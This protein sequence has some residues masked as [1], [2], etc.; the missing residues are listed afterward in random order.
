M[1]LHQTLVVML[2]LVVSAFL[3]PIAAESASAGEQEQFSAQVRVGGDTNMER[4]DVAKEPLKKWRCSKWRAAPSSDRYLVRNCARLKS[5]W[6]GFKRIATVNG[7]NRDSPT[8]AR[9]SCTTAKRTSLKFSATVEGGVG[10]AAHGRRN[11]AVGGAALALLY[12][13]VKFSISGTVERETE[14][15]FS[16]TWAT[17]VPPHAWYN[18]VLGSVKRNF[19]GETLGQMYD[20]REKKILTIDHDKV[21]GSGPEALKWK[22]VVIK[23]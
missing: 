21:R 9:L 20:K 18:C 3:G 19:T 2:A 16:T 12:Q 6:S 1:R 17:S 22:T 4:A 15:A 8:K 13:K 5:K 7:D 14:K 10:R 11:P 23:K